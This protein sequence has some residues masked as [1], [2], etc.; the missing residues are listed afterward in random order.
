MNRID[1]KL[2]KLVGSKLRAHRRAKDITQEEL[3]AKLGIAA[4][5]VQKREAGIVDTPMTQYVR[6]AKALGACPG[7]LLNDALAAMKRGRR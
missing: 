2:A 7:T 5:S 6:W 4:P 1:R 3:G